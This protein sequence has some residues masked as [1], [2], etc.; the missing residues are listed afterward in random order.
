MQENYGFHRWTVDT[1]DDLKLV[2]EIYARLKGE[3][4]WLDVLALMKTN[5]QLFEINAAIHH[6]DFR[7]VDSRRR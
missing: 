5:L 4:T 6:K 2:N 1:A 7:E 3:F